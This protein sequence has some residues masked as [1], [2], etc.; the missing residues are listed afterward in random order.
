MDLYPSNTFHNNWAPTTYPF[1][2][3]PKGYRR[4]IHN[5]QKHLNEVRRSFYWIATFL[6][7]FSRLRHRL[8]VFLFAGRD[9]LIVCK[10]MVFSNPSAGLYT[11]PV[12]SSFKRK[13]K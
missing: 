1:A 10:V 9:V 5:F 3:V 11:E 8:N 6:I 4:T 13:A 7:R 12:R 2:L